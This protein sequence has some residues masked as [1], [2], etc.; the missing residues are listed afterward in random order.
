MSDLVLNDAVWRLL[1]DGREG[2]R[3]A[4]LLRPWKGRSANELL[5]S[6][7]DE[8][9]IAVPRETRAF[10]FLTGHESAWIE[11][12]IGAIVSVERRKLGA[13]LR[14]RIHSG[15]YSETESRTTIEKYLSWWAV[16]DGSFRLCGAG[17]SEP[18]AARVWRDERIGSFRW[19]RA[20]FL[21]ETPMSGLAGTERL[22][23]DAAVESLRAT[24]SSD[25]LSPISFESVGSI[26]STEAEAKAVAV[27][28]AAVN[29][30]D[31][32]GSARRNER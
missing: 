19:E 25:F 11:S 7:G 3:V 30:L 32:A 20:R 14:T 6:V 29:L 24:C 2:R 4:L 23:M 27:L 31:E 12:E 5:L 15:K 13:I 16:G 8:K 21:R 17:G 10:E 1:P 9:S 26:D 18:D 22:A 28:R